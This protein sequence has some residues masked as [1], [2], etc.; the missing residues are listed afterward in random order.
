MIR[1]EAPANGDVCRD[2]HRETIS[3]VNEHVSNK[4]DKYKEID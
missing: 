2:L 3:D 1:R 4:T